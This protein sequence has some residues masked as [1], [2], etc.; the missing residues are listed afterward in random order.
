MSASV[1]VV[2]PARL[3]LGFLD[4]HGGLGRRFGSIGLAIDRPATRLHISRAAKNAATGS[5]SERALAH[6]EALQRRHGLSSAYDIAIETAIPDHVGLGSGTQ[7]ALALGAGLRLLE[8]LPANPADDALLLQ[9]TMRSGI[10]AAIFER[11]G[12]IVDGGRGERTITPPVIARLEFPP[13]WRVIL[14]LDPELKGI[15][16]PQEI[17]SFAALEPFEA[18][19][20]GE[21]CRLVLIQALPAL[22]EA[23]IDAFGAAIARIQEIV[24]AYFAPAQGGGAFT[25]PRV[26]QAMTELARHG[27][28]GIGQSSWGP[29]GF[30]FAADA[31]DAARICALSREKSNA[32][33]VEI[34]ICKGLN[35]GAIVRG[36]VP[37]DPAATFAAANIVTGQPS[38]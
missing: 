29:T 20:S 35:H 37:A 17:Q 7:L 8:G 15:H 2:A 4:L 32:L 13:A 14:V 34:A 23:D 5:D 36:D 26:A 24:G 1:T 27:A 22:V 11:G 28:R 18:A 19:A 31:A 21:I 6:V 30:A 3:H 25:S 10:G 16:G 38:R 33:G 12:V 9:R